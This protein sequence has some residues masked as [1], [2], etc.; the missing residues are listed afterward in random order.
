VLGWADSDGARVAAYL[1]ATAIAGLSW[2]REHRRVGTDRALWPTF[3]LLT[4]AFFLA[5]A[6]ARALDLGGLATELGRGEAVERGWYDDRRK[7]QAL[8]ALIVGGIWVITVIVALWRVPAR[9]RRYLPAA[10][11]VFTL[12]CFIGVRLISLHQI[13]ALMYRRDLGSAPFGAVV[14]LVLLAVAV[15]LT[16][17][18]PPT[19]SVGRRTGTAGLSRV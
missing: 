4:G 8:G 15:L 17:F 11:A 16:A 1:V 9:R 5:L 14:E 10:L 12:M 13:D 3:W 18:P 2:W 6:L 7:Y 19:G